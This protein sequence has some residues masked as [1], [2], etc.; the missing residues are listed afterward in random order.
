MVSRQ[1]SSEKVSFVAQLRPYVIFHYIKIFLGLEKEKINIFSGATDRTRH[2]FFSALSF[3]MRSHI[4]C[5]LLMAVRTPTAKRVY[6]I[7]NIDDNPGL[8]FEYV[9]TSI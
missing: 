8:Y 3:T 2:R 7:T 4:I 1:G 6:N 5:L 9:K